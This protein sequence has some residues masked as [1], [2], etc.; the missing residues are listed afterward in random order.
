MA[1]N[2][3]HLVRVNNL[4]FLGWH[5]ENKP[6]I[7]HRDYTLKELAEYQTYIG[8]SYSPEK[9]QYEILEQGQIA[10]NYTAF[11]DVAKGLKV[12]ENIIERLYMLSIGYNLGLTEEKQGSMNPLELEVNSTV[13]R[14]AADTI[15]EKEA[16]Q[17]IDM[18]LDHNYVKKIDQYQ[19]MRRSA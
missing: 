1:K 19:A 11:E 10:A 3:R 13:A 17:A 8:E 9:A 16:I 5:T 12:P 18:F 15:T 2:I 7:A 4:S 14:I 6:L